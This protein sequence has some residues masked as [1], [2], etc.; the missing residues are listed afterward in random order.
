MRRQVRDPGRLSHVHLSASAEQAWP[1]FVLVSGLL[2]IGLVANRD[3][4]FEQAGRYLQALP[5]PPVIAASGSLSAFCGGE[6]P[7]RYRQNPSLVASRAVEHRSPYSQSL[8]PSLPRRPCDGQFQL[9]ADMPMAMDR[10]HLQA[11]TVQ[12]RPDRPDRRRDCPHAP[13]EG[14]PATQ[15]WRQGRRS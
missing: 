2:L 9:A 14:A 11:R 5:G 12:A 10:P 1:P 3:G 8:L 6:R 13:P 15:P 7:N 4:R